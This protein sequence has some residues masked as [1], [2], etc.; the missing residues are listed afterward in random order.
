MCTAVR[1]AD[2][3]GNMYFARNLDWCCGYGERVIITP[4]NF[5]VKSPFGAIVA[6]KYP[7]YGMGIVADNTPLYLWIFADSLYILTVL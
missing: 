5:V 4:R 3:A 6:M 2:N 1:F 7:V